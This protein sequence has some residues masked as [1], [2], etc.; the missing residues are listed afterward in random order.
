M[1]NAHNFILM[2]VYKTKIIILNIAIS[3]NIFIFKTIQSNS[4][5]NVHMV[6]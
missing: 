3:K 6:V 5:I 4:L 2:K 1:I